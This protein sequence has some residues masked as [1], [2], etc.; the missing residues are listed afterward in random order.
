MQKGDYLKFDINKK[1]AKVSISPCGGLLKNVIYF[2]EKDDA[3]NKSDLDFNIDCEKG[4]ATNKGDLYFS[5]ECTNKTIDHIINDYE[6]K[7][8][9]MLDLD[10]LE[11]IV[12]TYRE[13][14]LDACVSP[15]ECITMRKIIEEIRMLNISF[16]NQNHKNLLYICEEK[17]HIQ[18][19]FKKKVISQ[20]SYDD[21]E[22]FPGFGLKLVVNSTGDT[23]RV[24]LRLFIEN[25]YYFFEFPIREF[26]EFMCPSIVHKLDSTDAIL[27]KCLT[28]F[29]LFVENST[30]RDYDICSFHTDENIDNYNETDII[31]NLDLAST[32]IEYFMLF[33]QSLEEFETKTEEQHLAEIQKSYIKISEILDMK[34]YKEIEIFYLLLKKYNKVKFVIQRILNTSVMSINRLFTYILFIEKLIDRCDINLLIENVEVNEIKKEELIDSIVKKLSECSTY[35]LYCIKICLFIEAEIFINLVPASKDFLFSTLRDIGNHIEDNN[36]IKKCRTFTDCNNIDLI[37]TFKE[38]NL[39]SNKKHDDCIIYNFCAIVSLFTGSKIN[40]VFNYET[41]KYEEFNKSHIIN[42]LKFDREMVEGNNEKIKAMLIGKNGKNKTM[43]N[44]K[45]K[46]YKKSAC[47]II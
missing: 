22:C 34:I 47:T 21:M 2:I 1:Y 39:R 11:L 15:D 17:S 14:D 20:Y 29:D 28:F 19:I 27:L 37:K 46:F 9:E 33:Q 40:F 44:S 8:I 45:K 24:I 7:L 18:E 41:K 26:K 35:D 10:S 3:T 25:V 38:I 16:R 30:L 4:D 6:K 31:A 23:D 32:S 43:D 12:L 5:I 42:M 13:N 36:H